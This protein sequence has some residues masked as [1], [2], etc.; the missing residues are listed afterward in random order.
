M[1]VTR[2]AR[3]ENRLQNLIFLVLFLAIIGL[4]AW[5]SQRYAINADWTRGNRNTLSEPTQQLLAQLT[6]TLNITAYTEDNQ[7]IQQPIKE[8]IAK[9]QRYHKDLNLH[10][11]N[12]DLEP[13][14]A[15]NDDVS[16]TGQ[17][18]LRI[19]DRHEVI[20]DLQEQ[21]VANA[22]RRLSRGGERR[23]LF[24]QGHDERALKRGNTSDFDQLSALLKSGGFQIQTLNLIRTPAIPD[25]ISMLVIA[26]PRKKLL[27]GEIKIISDYIDRGGNLL[28]LQD[29]NG[30][31]G[32]E[33]L[34]KKLGIHFVN[35]VLIDTNE[36]IRAL[37]GADNPVAIPVVD[38]RRHALTHDLQVAT[39][40]PYAGAIDIDGQSDWV[41]EPLFLSMPGAWSE[42]SE[43]KAGDIQFEP[44]KGDRRGPLTLAVAMSK[45]D[46]GQNQDKEQRIVVV[47]NAN[48]MANGF[49]GFGANL[50][51]SMNIFNWLGQ[52][53]NLIAITAKTAPDTRLDL[54]RNEGYVIAAFFLLALPILL[55]GTG[56]F[57]WLRRRKR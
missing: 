36:Q 53:D 4:L 27:E 47:G 15:Q 52:D 13:E 39:L 57:I 20:N 37:L 35:G 49:V 5:F 25:N 33:P 54:S 14:R 3:I 17:V 40:F 50:E 2:Y 21:T 9:Y 29:P 22:L 23:I 44:E 32:M 51:L 41:H 30:L 38:Y 19:G 11:V 10:F 48:F 8:Q 18:V 12:P 6:Q 28:W 1:K 46:T 16:Y 31:H 34:A 7:E 42:T 56:G 43:L 55:V 45:K 26:A 24:L